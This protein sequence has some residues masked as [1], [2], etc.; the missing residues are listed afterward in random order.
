ME[1][2]SGGKPAEKEDVLRGGLV[3]TVAVHGD[4]V[5][6]GIVET[7]AVHEGLVETSM[8]VGMSL[9]NNMMKGKGETGGKGE[10][11]GGWGRKKCIQGKIIM[12]KSIGEKKS[13]NF[14]GS[15]KI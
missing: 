3:E 6:G 2:G 14:Y 13:P 15:R 1:D 5:L 8:H 7:V 12:Q 9:N 10:T 4:G 11:K